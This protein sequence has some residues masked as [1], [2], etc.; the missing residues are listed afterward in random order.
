MRKALLTLMILFS[1][2]G[3]IFAQHTS[4]WADLFDPSIDNPYDMQEPL[5]AFIKI[6]D[7]FVTTTDHWADLEVGCFVGNECRGHEFLT[8]DEED[9]YPILEAAVFYNKDV[10]GEQVSFKL[11]DHA[12]GREYDNGF[13]NIAIVTG[14]YH[15]ELYFDY[16]NAVV[17]SFLTPATFTKK[18]IGY[19]EGQNDHY[20]LIASPVGEKSPENVTNMLE[21]NY[22][23]YAFDQ[24]KNKEWLN[25]KGDENTG[26]PGGFSL[27]SGKGYLYANSDTVNLVFTGTPVEGTTFDVAL[28]KAEGVNLPGLNL[29]GNPFA[30]TAYIADGRDFYVMNDDGNDI[31]PADREGD[32]IAPMEGVFVLAEEDNEKMTFTTAPQAPQKGGVTL[33]ISKASQAPRKGGVVIDRAIVHFGE[34]DQGRQLP[35]FQLWDNSTKVYIPQDGK[36][37]AVVNAEQSG[38]LPVCFKVK[39]NGT[40]TLTIS[41]LLTSKFLIFNYLHLIDNKTGNDVDL[42]ATPQYSFEAC[43]SDFASRF[44]LVF[45][46]DSQDDSNFAFINNGNIIIVGANGNATVQIIDALGRVVLRQN[47]ESTISTAGM[48]SGM[49]VLQLMDGKSLKTQKIVLK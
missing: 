36:D 6:D 16:D 26:N 39:E 49:Y 24:S 10:S 4:H 14:E 8:Y 34:S 28:E 21:N 20:Y 7:S 42:L 35:K 2:C 18:I 22:D 44:R 31:I 29:V 12:V 38:E 9:P 33:D 40:Y 32:S 3:L 30:G 48:A 27:V 41:E 1:F 46:V 17:L 11:Y 19:T 13:G 37:Y 47:A 45:N 5:V 25:Y 43:C 15:D 23:L